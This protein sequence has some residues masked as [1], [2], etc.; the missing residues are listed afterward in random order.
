MGF[1][2]N[3]T[4][5]KNQPANSGDVRYKCSVP[6]LGRSL[7]GVHRNSFQYSCLEIPWT[8]KP[9]GLQSIGSAKNWT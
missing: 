8:E 4:A 5:V 6:E 1:S 9:A 3:I 2:G 7:R